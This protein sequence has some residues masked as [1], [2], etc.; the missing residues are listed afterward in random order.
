MKSA[1]EQDALARAHTGSERAK[2]SELAPESTYFLSVNRQKRSIGVDMK[3]KE[4]LDVIKRLVKQAD[5]LV[6]SIATRHSPRCR[7]LLTATLCRYIT[8]F[9]GA[10]LPTRLALPV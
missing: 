10:S 5:V 8:F 2:W 3:K 7:L 1:A 6:S 9:Q 4:G